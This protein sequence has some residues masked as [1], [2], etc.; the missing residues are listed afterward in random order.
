MKRLAWYVLLVLVVLA[1]LFFLWQFRLAVFL[2]ILSLVVASIL[3]PM[4]D[5]LASHHISRG[6]ALTLTYIGL[7]ILILGFVF[8]LLGPILAELQGMLKD[9]P[10]VYEQLHSTWLEGTWLQHTIAV[11]FPDL[12]NLLKS[13][14]G[15]QWNAMLDNFLVIT[16]TTLELGSDIIIVFALSIYWSADEEHFK[17][18]WLSL[19][20]SEMRVRSREIWSNLD[21]DVGAYLRSELIQSFLTLVLLGLGYQLLGLRYPL[22]LALIGALSWLIVWF[23]G[24]VAVFVAFVA[25]LTLGPWMGV[26]TAA[27]TLAV[28]VFLEFVV[29]P[30]LFNHP[31]FSSLLIIIMVLLLVKEFGLFGFFFAPPLAA[32]IQ[33]LGKQLISPP[34]AE[35]TIPIEAP[36]MVQVDILQERL[37]S[38]QAGVPASPD[39]TTPE[40]R[41]L[42]KRLEDLLERVKQEEPFL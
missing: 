14:P 8:F 37:N 7:V 16:R 10:R 29:Q 13:L 33:I 36:P 40:V 5:S 9:L 20:P 34:P 39:S 12:N 24:L 31:W 3:R 1:G 27:L 38:I 32:V 17:R 2:F 21:R 41:N 28:L 26:I 30:R 35:K 15:G 25:G 11:N 23:G 22:S 6:I 4:V 42:I 18:L 19:L